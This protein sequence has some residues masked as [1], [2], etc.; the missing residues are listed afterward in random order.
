MGEQEKIHGKLLKR[1]VKDAVVDA[2]NLLRR[3]VNAV[4]VGRVVNVE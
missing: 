3:L 1:L 4:V 2:V